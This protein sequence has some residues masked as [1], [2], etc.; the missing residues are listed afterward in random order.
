[1]DKQPTN[2]GER[3]RQ[4][5]LAR[6][7]SQQQLA[8]ALSSSCYG[9][10]GH[11]GRQDVS[12]WEHGRRNPTFWKSHVEKVLEIDIAGRS[13]APVVDTVDSVMKLGGDDV[14]RR[15][16]LLTATASTAAAALG[17]INP[18]TIL[19]R[20]NR[21]GHIRVGAGE[22]TAVRAMTTA[23][24]DTAAEIGGAHARHLAVRYLT[25]DVRP[26]LDG[27]YTD[28]VGRE[29]FAATAELVHLAGWAAAD[30]GLHGLAQQY[31]LH[32]HRLA[33]EAGHPE[34]AAT[35]LRGLADQALNLGHIAT[36]VRLAETADRIGGTVP[37]PK[38]RAY[39][40]TTHARAAAADHD[41]ATA[42]TQ[43]ATAHTAISN[44]D[45][46]PGHSW[47][48]HYS[49]SRWA[50]ETGLIHYR[51]GDLD[52]AEEHLHHAL[53]LGL[54]RRR[55]HAMVTGDLGH[56]L[57]RRND[58]DGALHTWTQFADLAA[59]VRSIRVINKASDIAAR[60]QTIASPSAQA[61]HERITQLSTDISS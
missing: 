61:L 13:D 29:L 19:R 21:A 41:P 28:T 57:L 46:A 26:W 18:D 17:T 32:S 1:M 12:R 24:G 11:L 8:D 14:D 52:A 40:A 33:T 47:A 31:Y 34:I 50:H 25:D 6:R 4:A 49:P 23:L 43:L 60:L 3:I 35:A 58:L 20:V 55:T 36:A 54:D 45:T 56:I 2:V 39:Y 30:A 42:R 5:R 16:F 51:L 38:A 7:W 59:G 27:T 48:A 10:T 53:A 44:A 9:A 15:G 37:E 22:V